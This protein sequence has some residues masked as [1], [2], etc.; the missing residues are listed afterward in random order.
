MFSKCPK[1]GKKPSK[2]NYQFCKSCGTS[3]SKEAKP[4]MLAR[5]SE[6]VKGL[7]DK[8]PRCGKKVALPNQKWCMGCGQSLRPTDDKVRLMDQLERIRSCPSCGKLIVKY[9]KKFCA[10]CGADMIKEAEKK[11]QMQVQ[12]EKEHIRRQ[13]EESQLYEVQQSKRP[14]LMEKYPMI[15]AL[16]A[17]K[18]YDEANRQLET[19]IEEAKSYKLQDV[20]DWAQRKYS[21]TSMI[22]K[23]TGLFS[24]S[25]KVNINDVTA[26]LEIDRSALFK[27]LVEWGK[28]F[29][30]K[31]DGDYIKIK[32]ADIDN[33]MNMLDKSYTEWT[34]EPKKALKKE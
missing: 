11:S 25:E 20:L 34:S 22:E 4:G 33:L 19:L 24:I 15:E 26:I 28:M 32:A 29:D 8:C 2:S 16:L 3:L 21:A 12:E 27:K 13:Q 10:Y 23:M 17:Q 31:I 30:I 14:E 1:C 5:Q 18:K 7:L 6:F 9:D